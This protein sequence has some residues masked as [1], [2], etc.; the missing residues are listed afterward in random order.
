LLKQG[1]VAYSPHT[2]S[3][4][5]IMRGREANLKLIRLIR[6]LESEENQIARIVA[7]KILDE[8]LPPPK[9]E[10]TLEEPLAELDRS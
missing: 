6:D 7:A 4:Q 5:G 1:R 2:T 10:Y 8:I 3:K 9:Q